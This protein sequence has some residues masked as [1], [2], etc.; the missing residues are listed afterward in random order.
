MAELHSVALVE[1]SYR[2]L[3]IARE[4]ELEGHELHDAEYHEHWAS[5]GSSDLS[6]IARWI[7][8]VS[9]VEKSREYYAALE[10]EEAE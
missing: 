7:T 3:D 4:A 8:N 9:E 6:E 5:E 2:V 10:A 1:R